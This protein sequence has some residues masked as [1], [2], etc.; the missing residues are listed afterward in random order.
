MTVSARATK[1]LQTGKSVTVKVPF[2]G[3][4]VN[5]TIK[6]KQGSG[7]RNNHRP[8]DTLTQPRLCV[9]SYHADVRIYT[10]DRE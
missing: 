10:P 1:K 5:Q 7:G 8:P 4:T 3:V 2:G 6:A 9:D